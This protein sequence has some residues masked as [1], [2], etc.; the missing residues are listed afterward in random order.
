ISINQAAQDILQTDRTC[1][2]KDMLQ[3]IRNLSLNN[4]LEKG[5]QGRKQEGILQLDDSHY[6]VMVRPIQS[7][8]KV[9]GLA[10]L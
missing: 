3:I 7:E 5:L 2:G 10:L 4:W 6:K 8:D 1:L 9:T